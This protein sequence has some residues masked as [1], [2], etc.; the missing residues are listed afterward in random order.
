MMPFL[1]MKGLADSTFIFN[2]ARSKKMDVV[3]FRKDLLSSENYK[4]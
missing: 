3:Q 1:N 4:K 2:L